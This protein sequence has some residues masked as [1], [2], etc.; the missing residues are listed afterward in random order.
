MELGLQGGAFG[1]EGVKQGERGLEEQ[2]W[3]ETEELRSFHSRLKF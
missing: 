1:K 3:L 2:I